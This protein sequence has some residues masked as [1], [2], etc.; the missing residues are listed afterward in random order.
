[1]DTADRVA[2]VARDAGLELRAIG[3]AKTVDN[4]V[5]GGLQEDGTFAICDHNPGYGSVARYWAVNV[6]EANEENKA[7]Y[8]SDPVLVMQAMGRKIGFITASA[9]LGD[10]GRNMPLVIALP[11][12][13][14]KDPAENLERITEQRQR[15]AAAGRPL[16]GRPLRGRQPGRRGRPAGQL[17]PRAVQRLAARRPRSS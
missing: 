4:D 3:V 11:E 5:G 17:R 12:A 2:A 15:H 9:R 13:L 10:P 1:M 7:S 6:M 16:H 8:T 14:G